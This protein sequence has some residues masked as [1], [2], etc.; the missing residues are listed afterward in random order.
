VKDR[1]DIVEVIGESVALKKRRSYYTGLCPF[2]PHVNNTPS[3]VVWPDSR[4]WKC[5]GQCNTGGDVFAFV[6]KK[7][8]VDFSEALGLL[9]RRAGVE[10]RPRSPE[11]S[12]Q[13]ERN[14]R[15]RELLAEAAT[16][17]HNLLLH[18]PEAAAAR[19]H[20][21]DRGLNVLTVQKF[22]LGYALNSWDALGAYLAGKGVEAGDLI[23][24]G[25]V[26][27]R[28]GGRAAGVYDRF[29]DRL[30]IPIYDAG[31]K[32]AGFGARALKPTDVP[33]FLNSPQTPLFDK[34]RTLYGLALAR[35]SIRE[36]ETAV[37]VEGYMDVMAA[38]Q[39][40][41]ANVVSPMGVA[42]SEHQIRTLVRYGRR[43]VLAL[44]ADTAGDQATLRGL[45]VARESL[46]RDYQ[47]VFDPRGL[48]RTE[49][50]L[51]ADMRVVTLPPGKDPD[52]VILARPDDWRELVAAA[53]PIVE[54]VMRA[55]AAGRSLDDPKTKAEIA[56][57]VL[58]I[59]GDVND[60]VERSDYVQ[61]LARFLKV[62]PRALLEK[63]LPARAKRRPAA[64]PAP[65]PAAEE[66]EAPTA[67][68]SPEAA[69]ARL[70]AYCLGALARRPEWLY[71]ADRRLQT[72]GLDH[73]AEDDFG[74]AAHR[75]IFRA[76]K[77][78]LAQEQAEPA[79]FLRENLD[80][81]LRPS[82]EAALDA[83]ARLARDEQAAVDD[84]LWA[85]TRLRRRGVE[86]T[87]THLR[88]LMEDAQSQGEA[89]AEDLERSI[90]LLYGARQRLDRA[91]AGARG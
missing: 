14:A 21:L 50:R 45:T 4:A 52:E 86:N 53:Q 74:E 67:R 56:D 91:L 15:L 73:L 76:V 64:A 39:A 19:Q 37:I 10:L 22:Q 68:P 1:I 75:A 65:D 88:F 80:E 55:L 84:A 49:G 2:H 30:M 34:G 24:A 57:A 17:Y 85:I 77:N 7:E 36:S 29:R 18:A 27:E 72:L 9:A 23:E 58:P 16:Y 61:R 69:S 59:I 6:M 43:I 33:K 47:P 25:L 81:A 28:E 46:D 63:R 8:G 26:V 5:F 79:D 38:H 60:P 12:A 66:S 82:L 32:I 40:G 42:L 90:T 13:D 35:K 51:K 83:S 89:A 44:D 41:F 78:A 20:I 70:E 3:F 31:G 87:V 71:Q 11:Q 48:I 54:Y 62:D